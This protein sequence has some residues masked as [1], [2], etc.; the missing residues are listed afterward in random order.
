MRARREYLVTTVGLTGLMA[1]AL[2]VGMAA[3]SYGMPGWAVLVLKWIVGGLAFV[4]L[5]FVL[6]AVVGLGIAGKRWP[7]G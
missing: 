4:G 5:S 3:M 6:G 1:G 7:R 2:I